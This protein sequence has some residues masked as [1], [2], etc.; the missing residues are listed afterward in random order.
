MKR[1]RAWSLLT[2]VVLSTYVVRLNFH[3]WNV[4]ARGPY[5]RAW[6]FRHAWSLT[7]IHE[8]FTWVVLFDERGNFDVRGP[9][10]SSTKHLWSLTCVILIEVS[11]PYQH[12]WSDQARCQVF[13]NGMHVY[14]C[15]YTKKRMVLFLSMRGFFEANKKHM[16]IQLDADLLRFYSLSRT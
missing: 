12:E 13:E 9:Y 15:Q 8:T 1:L 7:I 2:S 6:P 3:P 14:R 11:G 4:S 5:W 16:P 10:F